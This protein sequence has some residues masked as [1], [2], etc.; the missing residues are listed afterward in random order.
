[1]AVITQAS[2][3]VLGALCQEWDKDQ[4]QISYYKS[5]YHKNPDAEAP[6]RPW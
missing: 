4:T 2:L 1:M 3:G 5:Q 6:A